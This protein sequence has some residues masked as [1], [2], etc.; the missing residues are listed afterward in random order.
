MSKSMHM[1]KFY[2]NLDLKFL[3]N[4]PV[5]NCQYDPKEIKI[6]DKKEGIVTIYFACAHCKNSIIS[7]VN[8]GV[9]GVTAVSMITDLNIAE[10]EKIKDTPGLSSDDVL[11]IYDFLGNE[12]QF[13]N[14]EPVR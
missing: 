13:N 10:A 6:L 4:C 5:C 8:A 14:L 9:L 3:A 12:K 2:P 7:A 11:A 1:E